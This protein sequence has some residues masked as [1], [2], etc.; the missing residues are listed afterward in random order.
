[1]IV[2][3][4]G[5][6]IWFQPVPKGDS[7]TDFRVQTYRGKPVLTWWQGRSATPEPA[8]ARTRSMTRATGRVAT[9]KAGNGLSSD[10]HEFEITPQ[11]TA[12]VTGYYPVYVTTGS[13]KRHDAPARARL[14]RAGD[15][16][17]DRPGPVP[18]GQPR[19]RAGQLPAISRRPSNPDHPWDYFHVN[20]IQPLSDG[21][22]L[23]SSRDAWAGYNISHQTGAINWTL[24]G[25]QSSFRMGAGAQFAFQHDVR[26]RPGNL[27]TMFDDGAGPPAVHKQ[28]RGRDAEAGL[29]SA[30]PP[31]WSA[32]VSTTR[33]AGLLRGQRPAA[34]R[35][36]PARRLG[37][38]AIPDRVQPP[39]PDGLRRPLRRPEL[40]LSRLP[41][42]VDWHPGHASGDR[43]PR[44]PA[45]TRPCTR[46][47]TAPPC[48]HA[49]ACWP[50]RARRR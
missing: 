14:R 11:D 2:G 4:Y 1:M 26:L 41:I 7:A 38:A 40:Q 37:P 18:V 17:P 34:G 24:G 31:P 39:R 8:P 48:W 27:V 50:G 20:S 28:S 22:L 12:L 5:G 33:A 35:R 13:G 36:R 21:D 32:R 29:S 15:R 6:L 25:K 43:R 45:G 44:P 3:P 30:G 23:I 10:L 9:V 46:A 42:P 49:G 16:H 19:S 47:G